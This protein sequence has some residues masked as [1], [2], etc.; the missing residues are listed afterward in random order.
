MLR[1]VSE[2]RQMN[3]TNPNATT[4]QAAFASVSGDPD[5]SG[6]MSREMVYLTGT[7][8]SPQ[9]GYSGVTTGGLTDVPTFTQMTED[10][11]GRQ[12]T[13]PQPVTGYSVAKTASTSTSTITRYEPN[14][15]DGIT[16][17]QLTDNNPASN[18]YGLLLE[19]YTLPHKNAAY[20][21]ALHHSKVY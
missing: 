3:C 17:V 19:D 16:S 7:T 9:A 10:W 1:R 5:G 14:T 8:A 21:S 6:L 2:R 20:T 4:A 11:A 15:T 12:S 18:T 13:V